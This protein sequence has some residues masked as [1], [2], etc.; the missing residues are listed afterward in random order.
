M[1]FNNPYSRSDF[2]IFLKQ[3]LPDFE[4]Q[5]EEVAI[6]RKSKYLQKAFKIGESKSLNLNI[7]EI[8]HNSEND[9]RVSISKESFSFL[10]DYTV[11]R[12]LIIFKNNK[13][14][15]YRL[16]LITFQTSWDEG[17]KVEVKP[18]NPRRYSFYLGPDAKVNTPKIFLQ[19]KGAVPDFDSLLKR[20]DVEIVTREFFDNYK[21]LYEKLNSHLNNDKAFKAFSNQNGVDISNFS[22]K[23]LGQIVFLYFLQRKGWLGAKKG[24]SISNGDKSFLKNLFNKS[25][26]ENNNFYNIY[27]EHLFYNAL[28]KQPEKSFSYY[29]E[30]FDCQIPFL[31]GG[32]F[33]PIQNYHWEKE[34]INIPNELFSNQDKNG[35]LDIFDLYNFTIDESDAYDKEVSVDPEMLGKVFENLLEENLRKG[36]GAYYTPREIVHYMCQ[37]SLIEY[38]SNKV[39]N[40]SRINIESLIKFGEYDEVESPRTVA[41]NRTSSELLLKALTEIKIVDPACGSGAFLVG[42]LQEITKARL[43]LHYLRNDNNVSEYRL[44]KESIQNS[45]YGVDIDPGAIDIAKLRLWLSLVVDHDLEDIEPLPNLDYKVMQGNSLLE[46]LVIGDSQIVL[47]LNGDTKIDKR[48]KEMKNLFEEQNQMKLFLEKSD[49]LVIDIEKLHT[50]FFNTYDSDKKKILKNKIDN[51]ED[52][53]IQ[54]KCLEEVERLNSLIKY[55]PLNQNN[56]LNN[57]QKILDIKETLKKWKKDHIRPFFPWRLHFSEVFNKDNSGFDIVIANPPYVRAD[58]PEIKKQR[59]AII[60]SKTY[61]TLWEKWDLYV[62]FIEKGFQLLNQNGILEFI[63]PDAYM[64]S[65]YAIKSHNYFLENA[66]IN[67]IN[68]INDIKVFDAA[69]KNII[70]EFIKKVKPD[71]IPKKIK[72]SPS[73]ENFILLPSK[74][75]REIKEFAFKI[76]NEINNIGDINNTFEWK[77]ICYVSYGLRPSS[78]ERYWKGEFTKDDLISDFKDKTH[79]KAYVEGKWIKKYEVEK[80]KYLEWETER[81]P[82]KLVRPTFRELYEPEKILLGGMTG[83]VIDNSGMLCNHSITVSVL[84][85]ELSEVN[86][87]SISGSIQK[88]FKI[89]EI[90]EFRK[91]LEENSNKFNLKYLLAIL[92]SKLA[93]YYL[94]QV[95]RSQIGFYPDDLK[96]LPIKI[97]TKSAQQPFIIL[98]NKIMEST[99]SLDYLLDLAKQEQVRGNK[100]QIDQM[101][102]KLYDLTPEEIEIVEKNTK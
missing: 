46:N 75:Q 99:Q 22:K 59:E 67:R 10:R 88:D 5:N 6:N 57:T 35:I 66:I 91:K 9:P 2:I 18:S 54:S 72:H 24:D 93:N 40:T 84:W 77:E 34:I 90:F 101:I 31:N 13:T 63:I 52:E 82:K 33:E 49:K 78:D 29:R 38:L 87:R 47:K 74:S 45:I 14:K 102:Y 8:E 79:P 81:S 98:V 76:D 11:N 86:N 23:L 30:Y 96:K 26:S 61:H 55:D 4:N 50:H 12:A 15:N 1:N 16:S 80:I 64:A 19:K 95:R 28:N 97:I 37:E 41:L 69:V 89:K 73:F 7:Y 68:F 17:N 58:N 20:F 3:F 44:K 92:N 94:N 85:K 39:P 65:K 56:I 48:T 100:Y 60:N 36:K 70:I 53:L 51:I 62:S 27:L 32:L 42:I 43:Y 83:A 25:I 71:N 21:T